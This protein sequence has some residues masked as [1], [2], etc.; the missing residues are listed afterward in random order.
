MDIRVSPEALGLGAYQSAIAIVPTLI[1]AWL[2]WRAVRAVMA[3]SRNKSPLTQRELA[4]YVAPPF[5]WLVVMV[6]AAVAF[7]TMQAYGPRVAI[8]KTELT[9][10]GTDGGTAG[11]VRDVSPK[12]FTDEERLQQQRLLERETKERV[13]LPN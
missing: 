5:A 3:R 12:K 4:S 2:V 6:V 10:I 13:N 9:P 7:S 1:L 11:K 8:P